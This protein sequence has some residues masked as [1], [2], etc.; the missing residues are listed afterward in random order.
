[1]SWL[2]HV[3]LGDFGQSIDILDAKETI[4]QQ[5]RSQAA[6]GRRTAMADAEIARL[7]RESR[8]LHL[9]VTSLSRFMIEK[10]LIDPGELGDFIDQIDASDGKVDGKL[11]FPLNS[12]KPRFNF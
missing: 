2:K 1:M 11:D 12:E 7:K 5:A 6:Q 3:L 9:A 4:K 10:G 8:Q